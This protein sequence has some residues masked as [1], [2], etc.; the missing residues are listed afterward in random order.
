M[1]CPT[2]RFNDPRSFVRNGAALEL[3]PDCGGTT[4]AHACMALGVAG[5]FRIHAAKCTRGCGPIHT[6]RQCAWLHY[7]QAHRLAPEEVSMSLIMPN[8]G[9]FLLIAVALG[10]M[11]QVLFGATSFF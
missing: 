2:C 10:A 9:A 1:I 4:V 8:I 5:L 11:V 7:P 6:C 3:C